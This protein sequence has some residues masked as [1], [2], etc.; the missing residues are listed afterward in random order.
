MMER[1]KALLVTASLACYKVLQPWK[2]SRHGKYLCGLLDKIGIAILAER[3]VR[4]EA[5]NVSGGVV[6]QVCAL[7]KGLH[8][9]CL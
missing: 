4:R 7:W 6:A 2:D 1:A 8:Q 3:K 9:S 5:I